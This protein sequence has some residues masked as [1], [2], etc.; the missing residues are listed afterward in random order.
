MCQRPDADN[1]QGRGERI[2]Q[3]HVAVGERD[4]QP[5]DDSPDGGDEEEPGE[6]EVAGE[7]AKSCM[8]GAISSSSTSVFTIWSITL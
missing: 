5:V 3:G 7:M 1:A 2:S 6:D 8:N 4:K